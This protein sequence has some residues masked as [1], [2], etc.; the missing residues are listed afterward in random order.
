[1]Q[2]T[3]G[4]P[5][6]VHVMI[7]AGMMRARAK[8]LSLAEK[9]VKLVFLRRKDQYSDKGPFDAG[10]RWQPAFIVEMDGQRVSG[11]VD[12]DQASFPGNPVMPI[13]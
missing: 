1:V 12:L 13:F 2:I 8:S 5:S 9:G 11:L 4:K 3:E 6:V 10:V 7:D